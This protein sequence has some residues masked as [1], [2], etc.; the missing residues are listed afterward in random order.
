MI[1]GDADRAVGARP[2]RARRVALVLALLAAW[3]SSGIAPFR[4]A[5]MGAAAPGDF[6]TDFV[7]AERIRRGASPRVDLAWGNLEAQKL[8]A[9]PY[10]DIGVP[11]GAH[12]PPAVSLVAALVP[13][14]FPMAARVWLLSS[15][16]CLAI[17][18][19]MAAAAVGLAGRRRVAVAVGA[20]IAL[21]LWPPVLHN[22][23]KGQ[24]SILLAALLAASWGAARRGHHRLAGA[25]VAG[26]A[27]FKVMP[28]LVLVAFVRCDRRARRRVL[29]GALVAGA[30]LV[31]VSAVVAGPG[32]WLDFFASAPANT[33]G[34]Q[35][36]PANT[37]SIWGVLA[38][39]LIGGPYAQP[40]STAPGTA[41]L[42]PLFWAT[43]AT[44]LVLLA[45]AGHGKDGRAAVVS[46]D[47]HDPGDGHG[48]A[49]ARSDAPFDARFAAWSLLAVMLSPL[50]WSHAATL[51]LLPMALVWGALSRQAP[52]A[53]TPRLLLGLALVLL[54]IP[55][56]TLF[57]LGGAF[58]VAPARGLCLSIH[59]GA[60]LLVFGVMTLRRRAVD[61]DQRAFNL[62]PS[63]TP[64]STAERME[65]ETTPAPDAGP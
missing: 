64:A 44:G 51:L 54:T 34:W 10:A 33:R 59:L 6:A 30:V 15:V 56:A 16:V 38:R 43:A 63:H 21:V 13:L 22:L 61:P 31:I 58:P 29:A 41:M 50:A 27:A 8:G 12:P 32:A 24:W 48:D 53:A 23:E 26:A 35:T 46:G 4:D 2:S 11:F 45:T 55:R 28:L 18:A 39:L 17:V 49:R 36:G 7:P 37:L 5:L 42:A 40:L 14:G 57:A 62:E 19:W 1:A 47:A 65:P 20:L 60:A 25:L 52:A 9:P 3:M